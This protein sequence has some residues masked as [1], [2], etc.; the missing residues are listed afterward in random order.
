MSRVF[1]LDTE[2]VLGTYDFL[3]SI[4]TK[5]GMISRETMES[6]LDIALQGNKDAKL[7]ALSKDDQLRKMFDFSL[8]REVL[9]E[10]ARA[11]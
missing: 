7:L 5:D 10:E 11:Q 8:V 4:Q 9:K 2:T 3:R 1:Q 6:S